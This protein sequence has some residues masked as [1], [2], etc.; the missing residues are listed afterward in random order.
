M[1]QRFGLNG[2]TTGTADLLTDLRVTKEAGFGALE[3]RDSKLEAYLQQGGTLGALRS[4]FGDAGVRPLSLNALERSTLVE[5]AERDAVL[6]RCRTLCG[7][8]Q[9]LD[10]SYLVAVPSF[11]PPGGMPEA[12]IRAR[13]VESLRAMASVAAPYGVKVGFEFLGFPTCSVSTLR[14]A[15]GIVEEASDPTVGLVIDAFHFYIG[16]SQPEDLDG[17]DGSRIFI[18]HLDDAEPGEPSGLTDAQRLLPG[19]GVIPLRALIDRVE[20]AG[21]RGAYS[22]ELF[23]P[24]YWA[25][26]PLD[27]AR[28]GIESMRRL[29]EGCG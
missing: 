16:G 8:A 1:R 22:L 9:A 17:L 21:Y 2:A 4:A 3:V 10:C 28:R 13:T 11:L 19:H 25:M 18:V 14:A 7:W 24:E 27:L 12:E 20:K 5:G 6:D 15:R 26:D 29:F 23:R